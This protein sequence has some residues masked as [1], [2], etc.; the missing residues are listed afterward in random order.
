LYDLKADP[1]E[2]KNLAGA[3]P[4]LAARAEALMKAART[5]DPNWPL[6]DR[7]AGKPPQSRQKDK[8]S[9]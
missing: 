6:R 3:K 9:K 5:E 8:K 7:P 2:T 4:E 1:G